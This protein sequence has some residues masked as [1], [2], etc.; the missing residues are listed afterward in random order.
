[1][2]QYKFTPEANSDL[3]VIVDYTLENWG[4]QQ[5][6]K[7]IND[8]EEQAQKL[9]NHPDIGIYRDELI[10]GLISFPYMSHILY[11]IKESHGITITR[12]LHQSMDP[13]RHL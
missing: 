9:A 11:Y 5:A 2:P 6:L 12:V 3:E 7:Y 1:M 10:N 4:N 13:K 8:L